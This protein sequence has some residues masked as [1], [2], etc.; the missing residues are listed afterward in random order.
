M[1]VTEG[2]AQVPTGGSR[3]AVDRAV[4]P[5]VA[6]EQHDVGDRPVRSRGTVAPPRPAAEIASAPPRATVS[7][8]GTDAPPPEPEPAVARVT[9][10][11]TS[12][13]PARHSPRRARTPSRTPPVTRPRAHPPSA[14]RRA[15]PCGRR[16]VEPATTASA[17]STAPRNCSVECQCRRRIQRRP[18]SASLT[19]AL[20][21]GRRARRAPR[22]VAPPP[23][24]PG[25]GRSRQREQP[26]PQQVEHRDRRELAD[27]LAVERQT[28]PTPPPARGPGIAIPYQTVPTGWPSISSGP[29]TPVTATATSAPST[30]C[31]P[32]AICL[33]ASSLTTCSAVDAEHAALHLGGVRRD[34]AAERAAGSGHVGDPCADETAGERLGARRAT[35]PAPRRAAAPPTPWCRRRP[36]TPARR[37]PTRSSRPRSSSSAR[38]AASVGAFAVMR[39]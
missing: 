5:G 13:A 4:G 20:D 8:R 33:T 10:D 19:G 3:P 16:V 36:R 29:A 17:S 24:R 35:S 39:T 34:R 27:A 11:T 26:H 22:A 15:R 1:A 9:A 7:V 2:P 21:R 12:R 32:R 23:R 30:R 31:A 28:A 6:L 18:R 25:A 38:A 14:P 37:A